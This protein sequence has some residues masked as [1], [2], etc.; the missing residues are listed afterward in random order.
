[1]AVTVALDGG[2]RA[3]A[4][5]PSGISTGSREATVVP[6]GKAVRNVNEIISTGLVGKSFEDQSSLDQT[7]IKID[8]TENKFALG[9]NSIL[10]VS[11][12]FAR[13]LA[14][15]IGIPLYQYI[16][17]LRAQDRPYK[18][19]MPQHMIL[20]FE[21]GKHGDSDLLIQEF[22]VVGSISSGVKIY[23]EVRETLRKRGFSTNLGAEGGF[24]PEGLSDRQAL[25]ILQ[26]VAPQIDLALDVAGAHLSRKV[27]LEKLVRSYKIRILED[28]FGEDAWD[29]WVAFN[30][31]YGSKI[32]L[33][34][35]DLTVTNPQRIQKAITEKAIGGVIIK[36]NQIGTLTEA[37]AAVE[38][39]QKAGLKVIV[40]HRGAETNDSF[41]A[42]LAVGV[43][44]DYVKFGAPSRGER[45]AKY[46]RLLEIGKLEWDR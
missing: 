45:V 46:N 23:R 24:S 40:S 18:A 19:K 13:A 26:K 28:P 17:K 4:A 1:V 3:T 9:A 21:G 14:S 39:A 22:M 6:T 12:A 25:G 27:S 31:R 5:I 30:Q 36:P 15:S 2:S 32:L 11:L 37:I 10:A 41:I 16:N 44:A 42:D 29:R 35:D 8:G 38:I 7:L 33:V 43:G 34:G 20:I